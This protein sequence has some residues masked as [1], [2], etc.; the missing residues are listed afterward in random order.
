M[1]AAKI[2]SKI[3][4]A[5]LS[6]FV[7]GL[8][9]FFAGYLL[10][11]NGFVL[12]TL[13]L[14][15]TKITRLYIKLDKK[16]FVAADRIEIRS[17]KI[18]PQTQPLTPQRVASALD[19]FSMLFH[20]VD[21]IQIHSL[22]IIQ[23]DRTLTG[24]EIVL[25][26]SD[27]LALKAQ[28]LTLTL[29][30]K[31]RGDTVTIPPYETVASFLT[32]TQKIGQ[33]TIDELKIEAVDTHIALSDVNLSRQDKV[34]LEIKKG[35]IHIPPAPFSVEKFF[36][37]IPNIL[38]ASSL[39]I[40]LH[41]SHLD[42]IAI[43]NLSGLGETL[44][45]VIGN[46]VKLSTPQGSASLALAQVAPQTLRVTLEHL[47]LPSY[48]FQTHGD[49]YATLK[50][51][52]YT[53][54]IDLLN[55]SGAATLSLTREKGTFALTNVQTSS[56]TPIVTHL[57]LDAILKEW[58][59][60]RITG[61]HYTL[62]DFEGGYDLKNH[63]PIEASFRGHATLVHPSILFHPALP[64]ATGD[65]L[66]LSFENNQFDFD[67]IN[68]HYEN[69]EVLDNHVTIR[70]AI[71][72]S[73]PSVLDLSLHVKGLFDNIAQ[74]IL[75]A[76]HV[77]VPITQTSGESQTHIA[78]ALNLNN[79][80]TSVN[81]DVTFHD[82]NA[83]L[84]KLPF[85]ARSGKLSIHDTLL[86]FDN[87]HILHGDFF[88]AVF[89]GAL[90]AT[91][92]KLHGEA[93]VN[94]FHLTLDELPFIAMK[95]VTLPLETTID[96]DHDTVIN[97]PTLATNLTISSQGDLGIHTARLVHVFP[98]SP[99]LNEA[100][101]QD[102]DFALQTNF[103]T[104]T[105]DTNLTKVKTPFLTPIGRPQEALDGHLIHQR[106]GNLS[107]VGDNDRITMIQDAQTRHI[108]ITDKDI[109][110]STLLEIQPST[111]STFRTTLKGEDLRL[112][113]HKLLIPLDT[114]KLTHEHNTTFMTLTH[115]TT[116]SWITIQ[117]QLLSGS[118]YN[119]PQS[120]IHQITGFNG[121]KE[122]RYDF[123][124]EGASDDC[125]G[126]LT[127][128]QGLIGDLG[129]YNT[130]VAIIN[131]IPSLFTLQK[132]F[133]FGTEGVAF[134]KAMITYHYHHDT[135]VL[136]SIVIDG[137]HT[138]ITGHGSI[139]LAHNQV[140]I[141]LTVDTVK[142]LGDI[143]SNIPFAGYLLLGKEKNFS[144]DLVIS[145]TLQEPVVE[146]FVMR[147]FL[148]TPWNIA[149]RVLTYPVH[150]FDTVQGWLK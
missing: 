60:Q 80:D 51:L 36:A 19:D 124:L 149:K 112:H 7:F 16:L 77:T 71:F 144:T 4:F 12:D 107:L 69:K 24:S 68:P 87:I 22:S 14:P 129:T 122:G 150:M 73:Q 117:D 101:I 89:T 23:H 29:A 5:I 134:K 111:P 6:L 81:A 30:I 146:T 15:H 145:G 44:T 79:L 38:Q 140:N 147:G 121:L 83:T 76:F 96:P 133:G 74:A 99:F 103:R 100:S 64:M 138:D 90:D 53:G 45:L 136:E 52:R 49:L 40:D 27:K 116:K 66:N 148:L 137:S 95:D 110:L 1:L 2:I 88:D 3:R 86:T 20:I 128:H 10:L 8:F 67:V 108:T 65:L 102:G 21:E 135:I 120:Y 55:A 82:A 61:S 9:W 119:A 13:T 123:H 32:S 98:Y 84:V 57:P 141:F 142:A 62:H 48:K 56:L 118:I 92:L 46:T 93:T 42:H 50:E 109:N 105:I 125:R 34:A 11:L 97:L 33:I 41:R 58:L 54:F 75:S 72:G 85:Q 78:I 139:D 113:Y 47:N 26:Y 18:T 17:T 70:E 94:D 63:R 43:N 104:T 131:A 130:I 106:D 127:I 59:T 35:T 39:W 126:Y 114:L 25:S 115:D 28:D 132:D 91:T 143:I 37:L 31:K